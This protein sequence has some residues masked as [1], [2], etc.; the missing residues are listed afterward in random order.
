MVDCDWNPAIDKQSSA[1]CYRQGQTKPVYVYR[2]VTEGRIEDAI[3]QRQYCK[4]TLTSGIL[5]NASSASEDLEEVKEEVK[6]SL[7]KSNMN[8][9]VFPATM[10]SGGDSVG[11]GEVAD[12]LVAMSKLLQLQT[13]KNIIKTTK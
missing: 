4:D 13:V 3:I 8:F 10:N 7:S 1:R 11:A 5:I 6:I 2:L 12:G 9:L